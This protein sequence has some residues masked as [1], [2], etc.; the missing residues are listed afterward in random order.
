MDSHLRYIYHLLRVTGDLEEQGDILHYMTEQ[1]GLSFKVYMSPAASDGGPGGTGRHPPL[2]DRAVRTLLQGV[3][4]LGRTSGKILPISVCLAS[5]LVQIY[6]NFERVF[7]SSWVLVALL[8]EKEL[9][10]ENFED[11]EPI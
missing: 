8:L 4:M 5:N 3:W 11:L 1:Y 9:I 10:P 6:P 2:Y 7:F